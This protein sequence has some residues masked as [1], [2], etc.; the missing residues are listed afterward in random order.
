MDE[1]KR[2]VVYLK[3]IQ[4]REATIA[5][6]EKATSL[7]LLTNPS[8]LRGMI[9]HAKLAW[10]EIETLSIETQR[11]EKVV[12]FFYKQR[13]PFVDINGLLAHLEAQNIDASDNALRKTYKGVQNDLWV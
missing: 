4:G 10:R 3:S 12:L 7:S 11:T 1:L 2:V 8:L 9:Q 13:F 6:I 5:E